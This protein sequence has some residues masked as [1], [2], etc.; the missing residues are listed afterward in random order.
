MTSLL[1][2]AIDAADLESLRA[3]GTDVGGNPLVSLVAEGGEALRCCLRCASPGEA[4]L[5]FGWA[6]PL[7]PSPYRE[8]GAVYAH[9]EPCGGPRGRGYPDDFRGR[10]QALRA[11]DRRGWIHDATRVDDGVDPE[12]ALATMF[13]DPTVVE[14]HSRNVAW[15]CWMFRVSRAD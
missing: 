15:G 9:A 3:R 1:V 4:I 2:H 5:L 14:V 10:V 12:G 8:V 13:A 11:Y 7:P 6:P